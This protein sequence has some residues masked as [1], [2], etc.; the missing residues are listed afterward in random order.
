MIVYI[1]LVIISTII[2]NCLIISGVSVIFNSSINI[3]RLIV[4]SICSV[5]L[6]FLFINQIGK[7]GF[8]RYILGIPLGILSFKEKDLLRKVSKITLYYLMN[9]TF[10]GTLYVFNIKSFLFIIISSI[11]TIVLYLFES[12]RNKNIIECIIDNNTYNSLYDSGNSSYY[13]NIPI[14]YIDS[15]YK[16]NNYT[17]IDTIRVEH[18]GGYSIIDIYEGSNII[19]GRKNYKC[20]YGFSTLNGYDLLLH[21]DMRRI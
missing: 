10:I 11:L 12:V 21:K 7:Y 2:V 20:Y 9:L 4:S 19:I 15:K 13:N 16:N 17:F 3:I 5:L 1:D 8:I 6:L 18:I 14:I